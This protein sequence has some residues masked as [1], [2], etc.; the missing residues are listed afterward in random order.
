M[1]SV[2]VRYRLADAE[3]WPFLRIEPARYF[4]RNP[5][6]PDQPWEVDSLPSHSDVRE[7]LPRDVLPRHVVT[8]VTD[9]STGN[10]FECAYHLWGSPG[11]VCLVTRQVSAKREQEL[12]LSGT[13]PFKENGSQV[14][15]IELTDVPSIRANT[16]MWGHGGD[17][18]SLDVLRA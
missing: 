12:V 5:D 2:E 4:W 13:V 15:R 1:L 16:F 7:L 3:D 8:R 17:E 10:F 11:E 9:T 6:A 18:P 14:V